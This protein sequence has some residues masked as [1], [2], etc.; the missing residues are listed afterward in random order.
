MDMRLKEYAEPGQTCSPARQTLRERLV[1]R[2]R[3]AEEH[4]ADV[5]HALK[6]LDENP[7]FEAFHNL[8]GKAGF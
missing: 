5:N 4:L 1:E 8:I 6:F 2:K 7:N 3:A